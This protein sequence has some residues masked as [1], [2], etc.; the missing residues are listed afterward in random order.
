LNSLIL[1]I[2]DINIDITNSITEFEV[3]L[4]IMDKDTSRKFSFPEI[5]PINKIDAL[6]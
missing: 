2:N 1:D 6:E 4:P 5:S 3:T